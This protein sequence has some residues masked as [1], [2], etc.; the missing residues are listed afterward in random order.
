M[1]VS[2]QQVRRRETGHLCRNAVGVWVEASEAGCVETEGLG[3]S[4]S[5]LE[6]GSKKEAGKDK[7]N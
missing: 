7:E 6:R 1:E 3:D 2:S 4:H 5:Y